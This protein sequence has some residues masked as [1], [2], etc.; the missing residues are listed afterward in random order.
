MP[1][2][3]KNQPAKNQP[4]D[5]PNQAT[6]RE[7]RVTT[8]AFSGPIPPPD[9]LSGYESACP[10]AAD[11]IIRMAEEEGVHRRSVQKLVVDAQIE[12]VRSQFAEA[13]RGQICAVVIAV[14]GLFAGAYTAV[15]GY[16]IAG[17]FLG[18]G[19]VGGIVTTFILGRKASATEEHANKPADSKAVKKTRRNPPS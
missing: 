11:R 4:I 8:A 16:Q 13:K 1:S 14:A 5:I 15:A 6:R 17:S 19:G 2:E 3:P 10:G 18:V 7:S 12:E 9:L